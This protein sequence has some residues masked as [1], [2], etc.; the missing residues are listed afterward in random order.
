MRRVI[1]YFESMSVSL[2]RYSLVVFFSALILSACST[3]PPEQ[4]SC[5]QQD[6]YE[7]GRRDGTQGIP[8][9]RLTQHRNTC[10]KDSFK[11]EWDTMYTNGRNAGLVDYCSTDNGYELGRQG[12]TYFYVCPSTMEPLFLSGYR[13]GQQARNLELEIKKLD[14]RIE[15]TVQKIVQSASGYERNQLTSELEQL[16][17]L[18][19]QNDLKLSRIVSKNAI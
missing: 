8:S 10:R 16:K 12:S 18:R 1:G 17:K 19:A 6:W 5:D 9:D 3:T 15:T 7:L 13:R 2:I 14:T 11:A 4:A